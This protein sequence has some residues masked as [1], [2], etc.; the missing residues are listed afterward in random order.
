MTPRLCLNPQ[1]QGSSEIAQSV[2]STLASSHWSWKITGVLIQ[3]LNLPLAGRT[4][5]PV[6]LGWWK[7][8]QETPS[9]Q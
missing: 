6:P 5:W 3:V 7:S 1:R 2:H 8:S 9:G 4:H